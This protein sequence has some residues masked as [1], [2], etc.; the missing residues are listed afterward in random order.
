MLRISSLE[1][2]EAERRRDR[3]SAAATCRLSRSSCW[4]RV[5]ITGRNHWSLQNPWHQYQRNMPHARKRVLC[6]KKL[7]GDDCRTGMGAREK[8]ALRF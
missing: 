3:C 6:F 4:Q 1:V 5:L 2:A 8:V 7:F